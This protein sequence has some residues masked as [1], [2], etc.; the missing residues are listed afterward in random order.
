MIFDGKSVPR[1]S[2]TSSFWCITPETGSTWTRLVSLCVST[3]LIGHP[4]AGVLRGEVS[5]YVCY[6]A[7]RVPGSSL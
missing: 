5:V 4:M 2:S 6:E 7:C 3:T 1:T